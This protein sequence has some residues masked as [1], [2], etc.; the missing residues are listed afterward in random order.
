MVCELPWDNPRWDSSKASVIPSCPFGRWDLRCRPE[1]Q[2]KERGHSRHVRLFPSH[3]HAAQPTEGQN[4]AAVPYKHS[5]QQEVFFTLA[6]K[7]SFCGQTTT[8]SFKL[9]FM[10]NC[11]YNLIQ[12]CLAQQQAQMEFSL[13]TSV[14][15]HHTSGSS[16]VLTQNLK[17]VVSSAQHIVLFVMSSYNSRWTTNIVI[18]M[19]FCS[20][21]LQ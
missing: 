13:K 6:S 2:K 18:L 17:K 12:P 11:N 4:N 15:R 19:D 9:V 16:T 20:T 1:E 3:P 5:H 21:L 10:Q 14:T 8:G 7:Q